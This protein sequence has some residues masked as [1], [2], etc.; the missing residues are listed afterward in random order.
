MLRKFPLIAAASVLAVA[1]LAGCSSEPK[2]ESTSGETSAPPPVAT[3]P[4]PAPSS[5]GTSAPTVDLSKHSVY[6]DFDKSEIKPEGQDVV[7]NWSTYLSSHPTVKVRV[8]GNCDE[9]GSREYNVGLGERRANAVAQ[10]LE[11]N[12][13]SQ[14]QVTVISYGKERP[15]CTQHD[16]SCWSQNRR[17]DI[18]Q[19]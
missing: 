19:Q 10:A 3:A 4:A 17:A 12:G 7:S 16:E 1:V 9:R 11:S 8:E 6:F 2:K 15:V 18:V 14:S 5:E 13:V